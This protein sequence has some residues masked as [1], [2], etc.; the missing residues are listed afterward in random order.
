MGLYLE[1]SMMLLKTSF[2]S[3]SFTLFPRLHAA[4]EDE[5][6][7]HDGGAKLYA[8]PNDREDEVDDDQIQPLLSGRMA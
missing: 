7:V 3:C 2:A 4:I 8:N 1:K 6:N 5:E